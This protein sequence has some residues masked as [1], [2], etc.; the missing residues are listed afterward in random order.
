MQLNN[1]LKLILDN[2]NNNNN[3]KKKQYFTWNRFT[4]GK[5]MRQIPLKKIKFEKS[6]VIFRRVVYIGVASSCSTIQDANKMCAKGT[7]AFTVLLTFFSFS[8]YG[9]CLYQLLHFRLYMNVRNA[10][11]TKKQSPSTFNMNGWALDFGVVVMVA[12]ST[13]NYPT[14]WKWNTIQNIALIQL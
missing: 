11:R 6:A 14:V 4:I 12:L 7:R 1:S 10:D 3:R 5:K 2:N 9:D 8:L 13:A